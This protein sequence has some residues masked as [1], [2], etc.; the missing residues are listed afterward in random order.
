MRA[1]AK[2]QFYLAQHDDGDGLSDSTRR[3]QIS[4]ARPHINSSATD[5]IIRGSLRLHQL[6]LVRLSSPEKRL[7]TARRMLRLR[8]ESKRSSRHRLRY[9]PPYPSSRVHPIL[10]QQWTSRRWT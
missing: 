1:E 2:L 3:F 9:S 4:F 5:I 8:R 10:W 7:W 6:R